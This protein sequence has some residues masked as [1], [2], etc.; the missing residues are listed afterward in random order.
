MD[1]FESEAGVA[2]ILLEELESMPCLAT[3]IVRQLREGFAESSAV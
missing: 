1:L 2:G 3:D